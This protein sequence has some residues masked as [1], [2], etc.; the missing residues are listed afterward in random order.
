MSNP[1]S[2]QSAGI[3]TH[4]ARP[5]PHQQ[6]GNLAAPPEMSVGGSEWERHAAREAQ[7]QELI[8]AT[9][10]RA[11]AYARLGDFERAVEWIDRA[12]ALT[13]DLPPV[14]Q[15]QR[16]RWSQTSTLRPASATD[17]QERPAGVGPGYEADAP[18]S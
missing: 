4:T 10:D 8:E 5:G 2:D 17:A 7:H 6:N 12:A 11:E 14:Y 9:F 15:R 1:S 13:G 16:A 3:S 18:P